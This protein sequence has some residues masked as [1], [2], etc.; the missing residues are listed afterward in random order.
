VVQRPSARLPAWA[1]RGAPPE[2]LYFEKRP[3][4]TL[5]AGVLFAARTDSVALERFRHR[6]AEELQWHAWPPRLRFG[7]LGETEV[8][9]DVDSG[10]T[11]ADSAQV[12]RWLARDSLV[13]GV[14]YRRW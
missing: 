6:A 1:E 3:P 2:R 14:Q 5:S 7:P 9:L 4:G 11:A 12:A 10:Y 8:S 13:V